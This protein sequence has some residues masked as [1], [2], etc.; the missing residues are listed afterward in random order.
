MVLGS[1]LGV[2]IY[3]GTLR[4]FPKQCARSF[5]SRLTSFPQSGTTRLHLGWSLTQS[6][7]ACAICMAIDAS[8]VYLGAR[9]STLAVDM[10]RG[11][12]N[13]PLTP[14]NDG[15]CVWYR[16]CPHCESARSLLYLQ[17]NPHPSEGCMLLKRDARR[18]PRK[19]ERTGYHHRKPQ[20][21]EVLCLLP[22]HVLLRLSRNWQL[23][24]KSQAEAFL[25]QALNKVELR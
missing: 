17:L 4:H 10:R 5:I 22:G 9:A 6:T 23:N 2:H 8:N 7:T 13:A 24:R 11:Q 18:S 14:T 1:F 16:V 20:L 12:R 19:G 21:A 15:E 25:W 3:I